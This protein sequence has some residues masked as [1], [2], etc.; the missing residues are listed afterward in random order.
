MIG[1]PPN[2]G[3]SI[4]SE[5]MGFWRRIAKEDLTGQFRTVL[6]RRKDGPGAPI[7]IQYHPADIRREVRYFFLSE[8]RVRLIKVG[9]VLY[10]LFLLFTV[11]ALPR[12]ASG[13][14]SSGTYQAAVRERAR[15]GEELRKLAGQLSALDEEAQ[16]L[17]HDL[18]KIRMTYGLPELESR[19]I[20]GFPQEPAGVPSSI[21]AATIRQGNGLHARLLDEAGALASLIEEVRGFEIA[22]TEQVARTP[23][24]SPIASSDFVLSSPFGM[25]TSPFTKELDFHAGIDL[26]A[27]AGTLIQAPAE[28]SVVFAGRYPLKESASWW[29]YGNLVVIDHGGRFVTLFGHC[30]EVKVKTGQRVKQGQ[31]IATVGNTGWSTSPHLHYEIRRRVEGESANSEPRPVDPRIYILNHRWRDEEQILIRA[32]QAPE[33]NFEPLP[34]LTR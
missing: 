6:E 22:N 31:P 5:S 4:A 33:G 29:R 9:L 2:C 11:I 32:R 30:D 34:I 13:L 17:R 23:S 24:I 18:R 1:D 26:A 12:T 16:A 27:H 28:G 8:Q 20:G 21:H 19:G 7:E 15:Q 10:G 14:F 3:T 25:R